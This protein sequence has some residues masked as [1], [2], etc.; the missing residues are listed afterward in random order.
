MRGQN[1]TTT[2]T[3]V[4]PEL[5]YGQTRYLV[6]SIDIG[7]AIVELQGENNNILV[8]PEITLDGVPRIQSTT[9]FD[10]GAGR[11]QSDL[12]VVSLFALNLATRLMSNILG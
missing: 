10:F 12:S 9:T 8:C 7:D 5:L 2:R 1:I 4:I 6:V 11:G 3:A